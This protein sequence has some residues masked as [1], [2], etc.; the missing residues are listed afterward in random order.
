ME[1]DSTGEQ[2]IASFSGPVEFNPVFVPRR[3]LTRVV[4]D[5][6]GTLSWLRHG[7]PEMMYGVLRKHFKLAPNESDQALHGR[8]LEDILSLNGKP[9][10]HQIKRGIERMKERGDAE[11]RP[12]ELLREYQ[13]D[14]DATIVQRTSQI[15]SGQCDA[16]DFLVFGVRNLLN[17][18]RHRGLTLAILSG[19]PEPKVKEEAQLLQIS[20]YFGRHIYGSTDAS[21]SKRGVLDRLL[22]EEEIPGESLL[23]FGDGP[24]E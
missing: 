17:E 5:F 21:F 9:S 24:V 8:L 19:T 2:M 15:A 11:P 3:G 6:D 12:E 20:D 14:L 7:W 23:S 18:L 22:A 16:E 1:T 4:F 10:I 13:D